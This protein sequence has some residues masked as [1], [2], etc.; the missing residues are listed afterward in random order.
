MDDFIASR[1]RGEKVFIIGA[2]KCGTTSLANSLASSGLV[3]LC[4]PKEP[5]IFSKGDFEVHRGQFTSNLADFFLSEAEKNKFFCQ[6]YRSDLPWLDASTSYLM[7]ENALNSIYRFYPD[8]KIIILIRD[9]VRR[10]V[11]SYWHYVSSGV[12]DCSFSRGMEFGPVHMVNIGFY[13]KW[14]QMWAGKFGRDNIFVVSDY[15]MYK[16]FPSLMDN[17][18]E[19]LNIDFPKGLEL[20]RDN[21]TKYPVFLRAQWILNYLRKFTRTSFVHTDREAGLLK[22]YGILGLVLHAVS[23]VNLSRKKEYSLPQADLLKLEKLY[24]IENEGLD[25]LISFGDTSHWYVKK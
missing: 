16:E 12:M 3:E 4:T 8:A 6:K 11:S 2:Q 18:S 1:A 14:I 23:K 24:R 21:V 19:F 22:K 13:K 5:M 20:R 10:A 7:S 25:S 17:L 9:P 15:H